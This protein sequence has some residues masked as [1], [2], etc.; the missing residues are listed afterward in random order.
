MVN[1]DIGSPGRYRWSKHPDVQCT[2]AERLN[3]QIGSLGSQAGRQFSHRT[4]WL[5][6]QTQSRSQIDSL[7]IT[8][9]ETVYYMARSLNSQTYTSV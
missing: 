3:N 9:S 5:D 4:N 6:N 8:D 7:G 2:W 1:G